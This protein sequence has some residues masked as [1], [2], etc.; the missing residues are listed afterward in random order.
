MAKEG[1]E[2]SPLEEALGR[3]EAVILAVPQCCANTSV[4]FRSFRIQFM[5]L[6]SKLSCI[7]AV[8]WLGLTCLFG[9][10]LPASAVPSSP[11]AAGALKVIIDTDFNSIGDDGQVLVMAAQLAAQG[12]LNLLGITLV[13]G[14]Q[15]LDQEQADALKAVERLGIEKQVGVYRGALHPLVHDYKAYLYEKQLFLGH[16]YVGAYAAPPPTRGQLVP[17]C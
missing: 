4:W 16:D 10:E 6:S 13:T 12:R 17:P 11:E 1:I 2:T 9:T 5:K 8:S 7:F 3:A 14:N 15:W